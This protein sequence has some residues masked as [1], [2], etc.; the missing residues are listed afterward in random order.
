VRRSRSAA[1]PGRI[2]RPV[3]ALAAALLLVLA[4]GAVRAHDES[5]H[6][7]PDDASAHLLPSRSAAPAGA[8]AAAPN[9]YYI[10]NDDHT[11]YMWAGDDVA[12]RRV[13][14]E[15]LDYYMAQAEAT[16]GNPAD[17]RGR[18]NCDGSVWVW[19]YEHQRSS[20]QFAR[21]V[22]HLRDGTITMPLNTLVQ[23][24]GAMPAEAVLR[25]FYYAGRL[26]RRE[27]L[28]FP[29]V[30]PMEDQTLPGG[31]ASLWAGAG[32]RYSWKGICNCA[33]PVDVTARP[34][35]I[36]RFTGPDGQ[37]VVM[38]WNGYFGNQSLGGYAEAR[39][40]VAAVDRMQHDPAFLARWPWTA[41]AAFGYGWDDLETRTDAFV[42]ASLAL[43][44]TARRVIVS[45]EVDFFQDFEAAHGASLQA[46]GGSFG[47][48]WDLLPASMAEVTAG[49]KRAVERLRTAEALASIATIYDAGFMSARTV[50]RDSAMMGCGLYYDHSWGPGPGVTAAQ[51]AAWQRRIERSIA[52]YVDGLQADGL[53]RLGALVAGAG[54]TERHVVFNPLSWTRTD[55][56]DLAV[57]TPAPRRV[58]DVTSGEE[59]PSQDVTV[60]GQARLRILA[61]DVPPVGYRVYEVRP[62][63][64]TAFAPSASVSLPA[65]DNAYYRVTLGARGQL[66][67][68]VDHGDGE[69]EL[70]GA[71]GLNDL[72][73]GAGTVALE[74]AGPVSTTLVVAA[75]GAPA[76]ET[77][78]TLYAPGVDRV[79]V[80]SR[81][82]ENFADEETWLYDFALPGMTMRH[83]EVGMVA[84]VARQADGGDYADEDTR[85]DFLT[86]NHFVDLSQSGR[87]VT[88]S[89]WDSPLFQAGGSSATYLDG[90]TP[91]VRCVAGLPGYA[92]LGIPGQGGD[93]DFLGRFALRA[94]GA[95][96]PAAAMRFALEHQDPLVAAPVT[97][98][99]TAPLPAATWSL[100]S[101]DSPD[102]LLWALKPAEEGAAQGLIARVWNLADAPRTLALAVPP[103][104]VGA[105]RHTTHIETDLRAA[106]VVDGALVDTLE[107]QQLRTYRLF[108]AR[109]DTLP[110]GGGTALALAAFPNPLGRGAAA[111][112][113][114]TLPASG[115]VRL[116]LRDV[117]G[118]AVATLADGWQSAG[119]HLAGWSGRRDAG[120]EAPPGVYFLRIEAAGRARAL[121]LVKL[122]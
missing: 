17:S 112:L 76:H 6:V 10:G 56:A 121:K 95:W 74:S 91:A 50:A 35:D 5:G 90:T 51:R 19:E 69:R 34:R 37:S 109:A 55:A 118:A 99:A 33:T 89:A 11:D 82:T 110:G 96:D 67:S 97:G 43:S 61:R 83:E 26:E 79:D 115:P 77:R 103:F 120:G 23:L 71:G 1:R 12:Y 88:L 106:T 102:V 18:F 78:V 20:A 94:H 4:P 87:G 107:R 75:G 101:I 53:A 86:L 58:V 117:A 7:R 40:P 100:I 15:M 14:L 80:E 31:V 3:P 54:G 57:A 111:T 45:N 104:G 84:R 59:V 39:D 24:Y 113:V 2:P 116:T 93:S 9:R 42:N 119:S 65:A 21:L 85:T 32:A 28:R 70:A 62:G 30:I 68:L 122:R 25:S 16:A 98:G 73:S 13:F 48:D 81:V 72:G 8:P 108:P 36:Y 49:V 46:W 52:G 114:Y 92:G 63:A 27:G 64:G 47:N 29:M 44:D 41:A 38:K 22:G 66:T 105:P 60:G